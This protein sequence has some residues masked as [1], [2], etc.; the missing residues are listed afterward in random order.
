M[1]MRKALGAVLALVVALLLWQSRYEWHP[2]G[3]GL[4]MVRVNTWTGT[5]EF[6]V[7]DGETYRYAC[8]PTASRARSSWRN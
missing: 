2:V 5:M 8:G 6:C 7:P 4:A 3:D 1:K